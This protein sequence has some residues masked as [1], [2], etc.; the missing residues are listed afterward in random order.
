MLIQRS[1]AIVSEVETA[2]RETQD[3]LTEA[4]VIVRTEKIDPSARAT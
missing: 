4:T 2:A 3:S 1:E